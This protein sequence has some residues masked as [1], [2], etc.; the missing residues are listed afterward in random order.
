MT[1]NLLQKLEERTM[2]VLSELEKMRHE[3]KQLKH[4]N[5]SL[6]TEKESNERKLQDLL[7]LL[8]SAAEEIT[9]AQ[10]A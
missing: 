5:F 2:A 1:D 3:F 7:S 10:A 9:E 6:R 4:E 8:D